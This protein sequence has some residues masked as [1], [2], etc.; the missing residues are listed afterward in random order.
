VSFE[1]DEPRLLHRR[2]ELGY[3]AFAGLALHDEPEAVD[4]ETHPSFQG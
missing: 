1:R 2:S 3:T 4:A